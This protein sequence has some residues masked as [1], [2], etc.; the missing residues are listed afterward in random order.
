MARTPKTKPE[1]EGHNSLA[2]EAALHRFMDA[3]K[4]AHAAVEE[5]QT[6]VVARK[7][8]ETEARNAAIAG[9]FTLKVLD[10]ALKLEAQGNRREQAAQEEERYFV[11]KAR[12]LPL[13]N[14]V[15]L[16][17]D[18]GDSEK[19]DEEFWGADGYNSGLKG[20]ARTPPPECPPHFHQAWMLRHVAGTERLAWAQAQEGLNPEKTTP[21]SDDPLLQ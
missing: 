20:E 3:I 9:G 18:L 6:V 15:Q 10:Q 1:E 21:S 19:K 5:A 16:E 12:G 4:T 2:R 8:V 17:L 7:K 11:F 14:E 13:G